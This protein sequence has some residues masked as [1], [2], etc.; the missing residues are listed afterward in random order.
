[1]VTFLKPNLRSK[2]I[3]LALNFLLPRVIYTHMMCSSFKRKI[4]FLILGLSSL[5]HSKCSEFIKYDFPFLFLYSSCQLSEKFTNLQIC[6]LFI[7]IK[8]NYP[9][10]ELKNKL[11]FDHMMVLLFL[12]WALWWLTTINKQAD[13]FSSLADSCAF[14]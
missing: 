12:V 1:M 4:D 5:F 3:R 7:R 6:H 2:F 13:L 9:E 14:Q 10:E 8:G 11:G